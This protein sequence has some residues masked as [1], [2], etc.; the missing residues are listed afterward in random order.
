MFYSINQLIEREKE[1]EKKSLHVPRQ[2]S[3]INSI[4][5]LWVTGLKLMKSGFEGKHS[6]LLSHLAYL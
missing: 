6:N 3:G 4:L 2:L 1:I 5:L